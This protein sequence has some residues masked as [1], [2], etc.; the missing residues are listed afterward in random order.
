[1]PTSRPK[2]TA[3]AST[4]RVFC[5]GD[6]LTSGVIPC[7]PHRYP[8]AFQLEKSLRQI[9][10]FE[11]ITVQTLSL[12]EL[13]E[14]PMRI[15]DLTHILHR[16]SQTQDPL[17]VMMTGAHELTMG[18]DS[19]TIVQPIIALHRAAHDKGIQTIVIGL[20]PSLLQ[21]ETPELKQL[22]Q[23][24]N[25]KLKL[26]SDHYCHPLSS[27]RRKAVSY[28]PFP[29]ERYTRCRRIWAQD[30]FHF[31]KE[32]YRLIGSSLVPFVSN[33]LMEEAAQE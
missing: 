11:S 19:E 29:I 22:A 31:T 17:L 15:E 27:A 6:S 12:G 3:R 23:E 4:R 5:L 24:V 13:S 7:Q 33:A 28:A 18:V 26:W 30:G 21:E 1:M 10:A 14:A 32:G 8:Y 20:P 2:A 16:I 9:P 25:R